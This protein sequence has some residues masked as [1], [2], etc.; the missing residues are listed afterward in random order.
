MASQKRINRWLAPL[1]LSLL[2]NTALADLA[3]D[4]R[5]PPPEARPWVYWFWNNGNVTKPGITADLE[6]MQRVGVGG[7]I[8]MDVVERFA[9]PPGTADFMNPE[10]QSLFQFS[11]EEAHRLGLEINMTNGPGW[12]GSSG[13]WVTPELSMQKLV[14]SSATIEGGAKPVS[15]PA[16]AKNAKRDTDTFNSVVPFEDFYRDVAVLAYP[17]PENGAPVKPETVIDLTN[18]LGA[19]GK[20]DW[21][22]PTGKWV[23]QRIGTVST[24]SSTRPPVKGGNGLEIDKLSAAAMDVHF[25]HQMGKLIAAAGKMAGPTLSATHIDSWEV[26]SQNWTPLMREEFKKRRGYDPLPYLPNVITKESG[27]TIG[28]PALAD[29]FKWDY[30]QTCAELLADNYVGELAKR[31]HEH[32]LRLTMEGYDLPFGDEATYTSRVDEPMSEFWTGGG[33]QNERKARQMASVAHVNG[34]QIVGA[35][36]F[37]SGDSEQWKLHPALIKAGGDYQFSQGINR[38][39]IHRYAHQPYLDK[40]PGATMGPWGLHYERTNTWWE[41]SGAWHAYLSRCQQM[42]RQG[43]FVADVCYLRPEQPNQTYLDAKPALPSGYRYDEISA[44]ALIA[45]LSVKDGRLT[46][47]DGMSYRVLVLPPVKTMTPALARKIK[48]L[49]SD[50][51]TIYGPKPVTSPSLADYPN[52]DQDVAAIGNEVWADCD[53]QAVKDRTFGKGHVYYGMSMDEVLKTLNVSPD[54]QSTA[55]LNWIHRDVGDA[56]IYFIANPMAAAV[57]ATCTFR[58]GMGRGEAW[59]PETGETRPL[60]QYEAKGDFV[61]IPLRLNASGS[62]FI[63]FRKSQPRL[64]PASTIT[65]NRQPIAKPTES[66]AIKVL[67]ARYGPPGDAARTRDVKDKLQAMLDAREGG[68]AVGDLARGDDP[69]YGVVKTLDVDYVAGEKPGHYTG[70]DTDTIA[71]RVPASAPERPAELAMDEQGKLAL[72]AREPGAYELKT[73]DGATKRVE[74]KSVAP[75]IAIDGPWEVHFT[76]SWG[77]PDAI[78]LEKLI[79]LSE[80]PDEG[81]KHYS[82]TIHYSTSF[83]FTPPTDGATEW[84]LDLGDVQVMAQVRLNGAELGTLWD[85]PFR[86]S[87]PAFRSALKPGKNVLEISVADLWPNRM[88]ADAAL[89]VEKRLTWS[90]FEPFK[91][92]SPLMKSGLIG[93]VRLEPAVRVPI[94]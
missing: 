3:S 55:R 15:A 88:I 90:S 43:H 46:L 57:E 92:D 11:V 69:A 5:S 29:R 34:Q 40:F 17:A 7:V 42:L 94:P 87:T 73:S 27:H 36:A 82:G 22:A 84:T 35:E 39:V 9:P 61:S 74:V 4:F 49:V 59:N 64:A 70:I 26:G 51:A 54:F 71:L 62:A 65:L 44:E 8:I 89:P 53:G 85:P 25:D 32:G 10:W 1:L 68:F 16:P 50:G 28:E 63:V 6:A 79:S 2:A 21:T 77:A 75:A 93:P 91:P 52:C 24:G 67:S 41:M 38:F 56:Q 80:S 31:A 72:V 58:G 81:V 19:D 20:L 47:P 23:I 66:P 78:R 83:D 12:C 86:L 30:D 76:K 18:K 13:P 37:T 48:Q 60:A 14:T 45:R 33:N